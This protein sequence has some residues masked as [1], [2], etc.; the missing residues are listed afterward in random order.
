MN[1]EHPPTPEQEAIYSLATSTPDNILIQALAG[2]AKTTTLVGLSHRIPVK[3]IALSFNSRIAKEMKEKF[4]PHVESMTL[5]SLGFRTWNANKGFGLVNGSKTYGLVKEVIDAA[6]PEDRKRLYERMQFLMQ[7]ID[8]AKQSGYVNTEEFPEANPLISA[9]E[10]MASL[11]EEPTEMEWDIIIKLLDESTHLA[12]GNRGKI[13]L[14]FTDQL[15]MPTCFPCSFTSPP[16]V[17]VDEAQDLSPLNHAMLKKVARRRLIAVGDECQSIYAFRGADT[18]SMSNLQQQFNMKSMVLS[19]SFRCPVSVREHAQWRAPHMQSP[20]WAKPGVVRTLPEWTTADI[21]DDA[22]ILCR[23]NAPLFSMAL[24]LIKN[25]RRPELI[26]NDIGKYLVKTLTKFGDKS[27]KQEEVIAAILK[28]GKE[29]K[30]KSRSPKKID[31]QISCLMVFAKEGRNLGDAISFANHIFESEGPIKLMTGHKSKGL[32]FDDVFFLDED[33]VDED[34]PQDR[35]LRYV[36]ITRSKS[37][38]TYIYS[39]DYDDE[40]A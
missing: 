29:K 1:D 21:P 9:A 19:V 32:E 3:T 10:L 18:N 7:S 33:L 25:K 27:I 26:G 15:L 28:W 8:Y 35:N 17:M 11:D 23:N 4:P 16:L 22:A 40:Q 24:K 5:N 20:A 12:L 38:L 13:V 39:G 14:D 34:D 36:I 6:A 2:A 30:T 31:D 37:T